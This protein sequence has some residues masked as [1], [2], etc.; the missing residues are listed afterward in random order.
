[1]SGL[2]GGMDSESGTRV[3][4]LAAACQNMAATLRDHLR[5]LGWAGAL[6]LGCLVAAAVLWWGPVRGSQAA[7][8]EMRG[9]IIQL[10]ERA[11]NSPRPPRVPDSAEQ[12]RAF[13][14]FFPPRGQINTALREFDKLAAEY[15]LVLANGDYKYSEEK[16]LR[17]ARYELRLPVRG[18]YPQVYGLVAAALNT[19]PNLALDEIVVKRAS[20]QAGDVEAQLRFSL[21]VSQN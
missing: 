15:H 2:A 10:R 3:P 14:A 7:I 18:P 16:N 9:E 6:G 17:L 19:M 13:Q 11:K 12:L 1:M 21:Y 5:P 4:G 8:R 20:R